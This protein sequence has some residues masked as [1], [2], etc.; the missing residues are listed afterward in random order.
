M[1]TK[2]IA[3]FAE[4]RGFESVLALLRTPGRGWVGAESAKSLLQ[5][6]MEARSTMASDSLLPLHLCVAIMEPLSRLSE[7]ELKASLPIIPL[8]SS[9]P[10]LTAAC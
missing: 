3:Q 9:S 10:G 7:E 8:T 1:R 6:V 4:E 2:C 5:A